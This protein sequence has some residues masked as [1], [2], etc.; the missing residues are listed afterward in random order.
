MLVA[1]GNHQIKIAL[2]GYQTFETEV[3]PLANQTVE[4]KTDLLR[5]DGPPSGPLV[6]KETS[7]ATPRTGDTATVQA[8]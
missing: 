6:N 7:A 2:P 3:K 5:S 8:Q 1:P 4:V